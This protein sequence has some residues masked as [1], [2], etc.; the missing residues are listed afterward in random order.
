MFSVNKKSLVFCG[1]LALL[2][3]QFAVVQSESVSDVVEIVG[4]VLTN[5]TS[6]VETPMTKALCNLTTV[7]LSL[8]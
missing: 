1:F 3:S 4:N 8:G 5:V 2:A 6:V 7:D